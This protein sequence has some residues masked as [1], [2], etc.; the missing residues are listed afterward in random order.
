MTNYFLLQ[1]KELFTV[2]LEDLIQC[3]FEIVKF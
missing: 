1:S 2:L 3:I